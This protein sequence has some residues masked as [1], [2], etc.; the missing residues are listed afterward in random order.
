M[1]KHKDK[2]RYIMDQ[3]AFTLLL[4]FKFNKRKLSYCYKFVL[5]LLFFIIH[6]EISFAIQIEGSIQA[7]TALGI[8]LPKYNIK[9]EKY[10][11]LMILNKEN[12][13]YFI[14]NEA[15]DFLSNYLN[16]RVRITG[17]LIPDALN[18]V[19][20]VISPNIIE[21]YKKGKWLLVWRDGHEI[22]E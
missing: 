20:P 22:K 6:P 9:G 18:P 12:K 19:F 10:P 2:I 8:F 5:V 15:H 21:V 14:A 7:R 3:V 13:A 4:C 16:H 1:L 11:F 17:V